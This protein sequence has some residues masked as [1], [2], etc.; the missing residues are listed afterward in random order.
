MKQYE[1]KNCGAPLNETE[2]NCKYCGTT[3]EHHTPQQ[4]FSL[5]ENP[6]QTN[7]SKTTKKSG[8]IFV[9]ILLLIFCWP[10]A[11]FYAIIAFKDK[12]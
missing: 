9:F 5:F 8:S 10:L 3:N 1:C 4:I 6:Q 12:D 7:S 2:K 11:I